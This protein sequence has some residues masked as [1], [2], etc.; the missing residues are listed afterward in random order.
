MILL[1]EMAPS[2][3]TQTAVTENQQKHYWTQN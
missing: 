3:E 1:R 2:T